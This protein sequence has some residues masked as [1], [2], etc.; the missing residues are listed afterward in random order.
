MQKNN[1][2][3]FLLKIFYSNGLQNVCLP[4]KN[5]LGTY[6]LNF[7]EIDISPEDLFYKAIQ[8]PIG[9]SKNLLSKNLRDKNI[10]IVISD[11][12]RYTGLEQFISPLLKLLFSSGCKPESIKI[13]VA[14]GSHRP[15]TETEL[16]SI[17]TPQVFNNFKEQI[18]IPDPNDLSQYNY[19]GNT[20]R[21][22]PV[23]VYK[24]LMASNFLI[25][26]G[27]IL[28]H[29]FAGFGGGRKL[30]VPGLS[31]LPTI[32]HNHALSIH[33]TRCEISPDVKIGKLDGN[34]V[35]EDLLEATL[36]TKKDIFIIN[37]VLS[38]AKKILNMFCGDLIEAHK[39]GANF[40]R[41][42]YS[43][44][45]PQSAD[46]VIAT[47]GDS[48][49]FLQ[50]HKA[51]VNAWQ[52][53][54]KTY[55]K[56]IFIAPCPEG[57]GGFQFKEWLEIRNP[58]KLVAHLRKNGE[59]NGQTVISTLEKSPHTYFLTE[60]DKETVSLLGGRKIETVEEGFKIAYKELKK[61]GISEPTWMF[62]PHALYSVPVIS[63]I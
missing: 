34:P 5:Y 55:G 33:P 59:V 20:K 7:T 37:T 38:P 32:Q 42:I 24:E 53:R 2:E 54:K 30:I 18:F 13:L 29:Y 48:K 35:A 21:G 39:A 6:E 14:C 62:L 10:S 1:D 15:P 17:L 52:A 41:E 50:S 57:L 36:M 60:M 26:T 12:F 63:N 49:N 43:V 56:I 9:V 23:Y 47:A 19:L 46:I 3:D 27:T 31:A 51:L 40:A 28:F 61:S 25:L 45:I 22:T 8:K 11:S 58:E 4:K 16:Q 44:N